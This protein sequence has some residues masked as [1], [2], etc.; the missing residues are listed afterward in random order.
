MSRR[1][2]TA[3]PASRRHSTR[4]GILNGVP[5]GRPIVLVVDAH[6]PATD[7]DAGSLLMY[8]VVRLFQE[9]GYHVHYVAT[10][11]T[12]TSVRDRRVLLASG[13]T[14]SGPDAGQVELFELLEHEG[15]RIDVAFLS[16]VTVG[17]HFIEDVVRHCRRARIVFETHDL[18]YLRQ[19]RTAQMAGDR[20][21]LYEAAALKE[22][23]VHV[24]RVADVTLVV[25]DL[26]RGLLEEAAPGA[27][28]RASPLVQDVVGR[29][30]DFS[31]RSGVAFIG[32]YR[33]EPNVDAVRYFLDEVWP[34]VR[35][36]SPDLAFHAVGADMPAELR[37]RTDPGFI[38]AGHV[39]DLASILGRVRVTVAP[40]RIGAGVKG[41]VVMSLAHGVPCVVS[42]IAAEGI[43]TPDG[44]TLLA[45][46]SEAFAA[47]ILAL[48]GDPSEWQR[49]SDGG[50]RWVRETVSVARARERLRALLDEIGAPLPATGDVTSGRVPSEAGPLG[51]GEGATA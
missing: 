37:R 14:V 42:S 31:S 48:H 10:A 11:A 2:L 47:A 19:E 5:Q 7:R 16:R 18:H 45:P 9:L 25:S 41:K 38:A 24:A 30:R 36:G 22:L 17:G 4:P 28:V 26:E 35:L 1:T 49:H 34:A 27:R 21:G 46:D 12:D 20:I 39:E 40:L 8:H 43:V 44:G 13:A 6:L 3:S 29:F 32:G 50:M 15:E 23:E 51:A 33:H